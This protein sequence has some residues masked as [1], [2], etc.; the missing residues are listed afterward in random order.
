ME[1]EPPM[2]IPPLL[3]PVVSFCRHSSGS[4]VWILVFINHF[5]LSDVDLTTATWIFVDYIVTWDSFST[6]SIC[7]NKRESPSWL[8][9]HS[10]TIISHVWYLHLTQQCMETLLQALFFLIFL[11]VCWVI[12]PCYKNK[13]KMYEV[14]RVIHLAWGLWIDVLLFFWGTSLC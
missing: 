8:E 1:R 3:I 13:G 7:M 2:H 9:S 14:G 4:L 12:F 11:V 5:G 10:D 6:S